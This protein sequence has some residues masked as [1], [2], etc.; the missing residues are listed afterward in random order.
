[1]PYKF[2]KVKFCW[3]LLPNIRRNLLVLIIKKYFRVPAVGYIFGDTNEV[4]NT[5]K[6]LQHSQG[7]KCRTA[8]RPVR[9]FWD[10]IGGSAKI[11]EKFR[12]LATPAGPA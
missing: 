3:P 1:M 6:N 7:W 4:Q 12:W 10:E 9:L 11:R 2:Y 8:R 5:E